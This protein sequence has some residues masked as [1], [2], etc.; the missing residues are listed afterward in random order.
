MFSRKKLYVYKQDNYCKI[1][2]KGITPVPQFVFSHSD[3]AFKH[4]L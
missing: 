4:K 2:I 3:Y 1:K